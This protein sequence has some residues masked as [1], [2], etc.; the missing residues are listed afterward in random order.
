M[1]GRSL[2]DLSQSIAVG[3]SPLTSSSSESV[4][5]TSGCVWEGGGGVGI[6]VVHVQRAASPFLA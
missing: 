5:N 2:F 3:S 6:Y 1:D 4:I